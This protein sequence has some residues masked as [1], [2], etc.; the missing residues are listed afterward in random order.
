MTTDDFYP[1]GLTPEAITALQR[2]V[3]RELHR[4]EYPT[5]RRRSGTRPARDPGRHFTEPTAAT[6]SSGS[7]A[8]PLPD[9]HDHPDGQDVAGGDRPSTGQST[10]DPAPLLLTPAQAANLLQVPESW[11]RR[12]AA[13]RLVPCTFLGKHLRFSPANLNKIVADATRPATTHHAGPDGSGCRRSRRRG[14]NYGHNRR[15]PAARTRSAD[16]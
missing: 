9:G 3:D 10:A 4:E 2:D 1:D 13:R 14:P 5:H 11:L 12:S 15:P 16:C 6:R 7:S 8:S